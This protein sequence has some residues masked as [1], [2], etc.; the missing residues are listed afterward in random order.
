VVVVVVIVVAIVGFVI[1]ES[2][3][4]VVSVTGINV[5][6]PDN[7]CGYNANSIGYYGFNDS[8]GVTDSFAFPLPNFNATNCTITGVTTNTSGFG[9]SNVGVPL[10]LP[11]GGNGTLYASISLP[12]SAWSGYLNLVFR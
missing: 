1:Y 11:G 9:L 5:W 8:P 7:V 4:P 2:L 3:A 6:A 10:T 12:G